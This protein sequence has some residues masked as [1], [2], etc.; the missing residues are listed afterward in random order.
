MRKVAFL[1][2]LG[3]LGVCQAGRSQCVDGTCSAPGASFASPF[4]GPQV[5]YLR[6]ADVPVIYYCPCVAL[7]GYSPVLPQAG[8]VELRSYYG[9]PVSYG[10]PQVS[11]PVEPA[12][13]GRA[14]TA[15]WANGYSSYNTPH[16]HRNV[17][18]QRYR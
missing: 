4:A 2:V 5:P 1:A 9:P 13:I 16:L 10:Y 6:G 18:R 11:V 17:V 7:G 3:V 14:P 15:S 8:V 12:Y